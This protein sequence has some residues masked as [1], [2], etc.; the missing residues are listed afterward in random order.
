MQAAAGCKASDLLDFFEEPAS[1]IIAVRFNNEICSL[2]QPLQNSGT[3]EAVCTGSSEG[4]A[5]YRRSL[6][7][8]LAAAAN[9]LFPGKRLAVGHSLGYGYY[10][11]LDTDAPVSAES[12]NMLKTKME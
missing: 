8:L 3:L 7:F 2:I 4:S 11:T 9:E 10:Y 12:V 1:S 5:I 6:C